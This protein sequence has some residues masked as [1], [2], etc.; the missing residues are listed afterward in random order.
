MCQLIENKQSRP[1]LI[2]TF[3]GCFQTLANRIRRRGE[4]LFAVET[5][6]FGLK[7]P[8]VAPI[9]ASKDCAILNKI[10]AVRRFKARAAS[11]SERPC[12]ES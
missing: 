4:K 9:A 6:T 10:T 2:A 1:V 3:Q 5:P 12:A 7:H 11:R 8:P